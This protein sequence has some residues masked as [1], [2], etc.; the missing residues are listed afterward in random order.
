MTAVG[1]AESP[2]T[3]LRM[4][5]RDALWLSVVG[6]A[7]LTAFPY[8]LPILSSDGTWYY[9]VYYSDPPLL[10]A[11]MLVLAVSRRHAARRRERAFWAA[12]LAAIACWMG[13]ALMFIVLP[14][15]T[16]GRGG[17]LAADLLNVLYYLFAF[18]AATALPHV[19]GSE[20]E[21][22]H[23]GITPQTLGTWLFC[24]FLMSY[25]V[26]IPVTLEPD[27]Y[28]SYVPSYLMYL[29][30]DVLLVASYVRLAQIAAGNGWR[31]TYGLVAITGGLWLVL[32]LV[33]FLQWIE[34]LAWVDSGTSLDLLWIV[35]YLPLVAAARL[36]AM[37]PSTP[38]PAESGPAAHARKHIGR[39]TLVLYTAAFPVLHFA[40][41]AVGLSEPAI[42]QAREACVFLAVATLGSLALLAHRQLELQRARAEARIRDQK[43]R[44]RALS[45]RLSRTQE[46]ERRQIAR[47][48]HDE[49]GQQLTGLRL[50]LGALR[51]RGGDIA[52][53]GV[54]EIE[55]QFGE[56]LRQVRELSLSLRPTMLDDHGLVAALKYLFRRLC[57]QT[58]L[59]IRFEQLDD[60]ADLPAEAQLAAYRVVQEAL[61]NVLRH[62]DV[63]EVVV[64]MDA[65]RHS[66]RVDVID[67][68]VGFD[69][70][71]SVVG[72]S[73]GIDGMHERVELVGGALDVQ[74]APERGT[75]VTMTLPRSA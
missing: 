51:H 23:P 67:H 72:A 73:C 47:E 39:A 40:G 2:P 15:F 44:L 46:D 70:G 58:D 25:F 19:A 65:D 37:R 74:S 75:R 30:L 12:W 10:A 56:L 9:A 69:P 17:E 48:L 54:T 28:A 49:I 42:R 62:A 52:D 41:Y 66:Y 60:F 18:L 6:I 13:N 20:S 27:I 35:P 31:R 22:D 64:R 57:D 53:S 34:V 71:R 8:T 14:D 43:D 16:L 5:W 63:D 45:H 26:L 29:T 24:F 68:G 4:L 7:L 55:E 32:D 50:S 33:E 3:R 21:P 1:P 38:L 61:T 11:I 36:E 59:Q